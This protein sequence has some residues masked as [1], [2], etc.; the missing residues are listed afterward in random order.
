MKQ[1]TWTNTEVFLS[2]VSGTCRIMQFNSTPDIIAF[3]GGATTS[4][5]NLA[6]DTK[7]IIRAI[8][9]GAGSSIQVNNTAAV[10]SNAGA[11]NMTGITLGAREDISLYSDMTFYE[12]VIRTQADDAA[13]QTAI[14]NCFAR[15][16]G[17]FL[18]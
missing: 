12:L 7:G 4:N 5:S 17:F 2:G 9:N 14:Y 8:F 18:I 13:T 1:K 3:A 10:T 15:K 6:L 16:H 11:G